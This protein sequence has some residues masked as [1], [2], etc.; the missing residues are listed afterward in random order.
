M[1]RGSD[2]KND[3]RMTREAPARTDEAAGKAI[4]CIREPLPVAGSR[5]HGDIDYRL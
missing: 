2:T 5:R 3:N 4:G 1:Y